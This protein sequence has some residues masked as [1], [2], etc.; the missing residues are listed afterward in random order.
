MYVGREISGDNGGR[1][2]N[3]FFLSFEEIKTKI[4]LSDL[5]LRFRRDAMGDVDNEQEEEEEEEEEENEVEEEDEQEEED[6]KE[7]EEK[8][9]SCSFNS[10]KNG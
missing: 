7:E 4:L 5:F 9:S 2:K 8:V 1:R 6:E 3:L 10:K